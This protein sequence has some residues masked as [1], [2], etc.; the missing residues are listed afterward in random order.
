MST[1]MMQRKAKYTEQDLNTTLELEQ[2]E[3]ARAMRAIDRF[4]RMLKRRT[5]EPLPTEQEQQA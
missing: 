1:P 2:Q 3:L 5:A 4:E